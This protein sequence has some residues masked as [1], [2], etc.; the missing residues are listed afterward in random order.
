MNINEFTQLYER[1]NL[2]VG[3]RL[4]FFGAKYDGRWSK[5]GVHIPLTE[6]EI[7]EISQYWRGRPCINYLSPTTGRPLKTKVLEWGIN[8][9]VKG[10]YNKA[11]EIQIFDDREEAVRAYDIY[12]PT[13]VAELREIM[14]EKT[15]KYQQWIDDLTE[16]AVIPF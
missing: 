1:G 12:L 4:W 7:T 15:A 5:P 14:E 16:A 2:Y 6:G 11:N 13:K 8:Y 10:G 3:Q 9:Q